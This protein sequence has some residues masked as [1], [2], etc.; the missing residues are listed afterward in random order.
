MSKCNP[1]DESEYAAFRDN[2]SRIRTD[3]SEPDEHDPS[4]LDLD[5]QIFNT[6]EI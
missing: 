6:D 4:N 5:M 1:Y 2:E 3:D